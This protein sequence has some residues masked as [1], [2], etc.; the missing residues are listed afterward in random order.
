MESLDYWRLCDELNVIQAAL[1]V[2]GSDPSTDAKY[3]EGNQ[4]ESRPPGY[5]AAKTAIANALKR[6]AI[7]GESQPLFEYDINGNTCGEVV[8]S[9][10]LEKSLIEV[11]S[12][13]SWLAARGLKSGFFF[14][15]AG[16]NPD[17]LDPRH[18]HYAP[19]LAAPRA[20]V[21]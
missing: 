8:G 12:L 1:L 13:R 21:R 16:S 15:E 11:A 10:D 14:P 9:I 18:P 4:V 2:V 6:G 7:V 17:Y 19:K 3:V 5:E 20:N